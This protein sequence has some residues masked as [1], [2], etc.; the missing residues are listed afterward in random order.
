MT[1]MHRVGMAVVIGALAAGAA[2]TAQAQIQGM[3]LFTN[4]RYATGFRVLA[5]LGLPTSKTTSL[6]DYNVIQ[7]GV[8]FALGPV[9]IGA[10]L[11]TTSQTFKAVQGGTPTSLGSQAKFTASALLQLRVYG[12]GLS[13]LSLSLFGGASMDVNAFNFTKLSAFGSLPT[14]VQDSIKSANP[15]VLTIPVGVA[16]GLKLP[17]VIISPN[18]WIAPRLNMTRVIGCGSSCPSS[19]SEFRWAAGVDVPIFRIISVRAAYDSG[20]I[21]NLVTGATTTV[22]NFGVGASIGIGGMR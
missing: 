6:G 8:A 15:K 5:D 12:G 9:G 22:S 2:A 14:A 3:P 21:K 19:T 11:G 20:K 17:L 1:R 4:P 18:L 16:L 10:N 13:P 7:G